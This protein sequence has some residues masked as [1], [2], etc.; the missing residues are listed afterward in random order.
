MLVWIDLWKVGFDFDYGIGYGVGVFFGVYEGLQWIVKIGMVLFKF[1]MILFNE[2]GY[3]LVGEYGIWLE[4]LEVVIEFWEIVGGECF[5]LGFEMIMLVLFDC[6]LI[7][8]GFL[9]VV[10]CDWFNWYYVWVCEEI[11]FLVG[12]KQC[13]WFEQVI[14]LVQECVGLR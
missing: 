3:Y 8:V 7:F 14:E 5:M 2:L 10:E 6:W 1:G 9:M 13:I 11:G 4:N 12:V